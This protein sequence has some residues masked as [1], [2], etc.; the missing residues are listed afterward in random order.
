MR[1][2]AAWLLEY[3][4]WIH[5]YWIFKDSLE[6]TFGHWAPCRALSRSRIFGMVS[7]LA[8]SVKTHLVNWLVWLSI[9][10]YLNYFGCTYNSVLTSCATKSVMEYR[11]LLDGVPHAFS[12]GQFHAVRSALQLTF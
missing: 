12:Q 1:S 7:V 4:F 6:V 8:L 10:S 11:C 9:G 5:L 2:S 3:C